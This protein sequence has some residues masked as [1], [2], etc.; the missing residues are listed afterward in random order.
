MARTVKNSKIN[1][2]PCNALPKKVVR[3]LRDKIR[4]RALE[5]LEVLQAEREVVREEVRAEEV[6]EE[7]RTGKRVERDYGPGIN[8]PVEHNVLNITNATGGRPS[9]YDQFRFPHIGYVLCK[10]RGFTNEELARVFDVSVSTV[11]QWMWQKEEFKKAVRRGRDEFDTE[12]VEQALKKRALGFSYD[13]ISV[14][15]TKITGKM[16]D[17]TEVL[18]PAVETTTTHKTIAPD[19]RSIMYWLQNRQPD[20]W[21]NTAHVKVEIPLLDGAGMEEEV[22]IETMSTAD[23]FALRDMS[24]KAI[25]IKSKTIDISEPEQRQHTVEEILAAADSMT[26][27]LAERQKEI[28]SQKVGTA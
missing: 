28:N 25:E 14:K 12:N 9:I 2:V 24:M 5:R 3:T 6:R 19:P 20:R 18:I 13:E 22:D 1:T 23:L 26:A 16:A 10:E 17:G 21:K 27:K 8:I 15:K 4:D 7:H 11:N